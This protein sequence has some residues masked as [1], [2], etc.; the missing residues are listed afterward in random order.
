MPD[1]LERLTLAI[2]RD[3][4]VISITLQEEDDAQVIFET[5][6]ARG[7]ELHANDLIRNFIFTAAD[8]EGSNTKQLYVIA[9]GGLNLIK[10]IQAS[11]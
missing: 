11:G 2:F 4:K 8:R 10:M 5:L 7:A 6:N 3:L 9:S 1:F